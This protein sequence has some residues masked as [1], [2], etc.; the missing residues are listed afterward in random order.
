M[1]AQDGQAI[2]FA[3][4]GILGSGVGGVATIGGRNMATMIH[5]I[6]HS[7]GG[8]SDEYTA[9]QAGRKKGAKPTRNTNIATS[10]DPDQ[11][12]WSHFLKAKVRGVGMHPGGA[13]FVKGAWRPTAGKCSMASGGSFCAVCRE[14]LVLRIY[15]YCDPI[16]AAE[17][18]AHSFDGDLDLPIGRRGVSFEVRVLQ[19][20]S[21][22]L[23]VDWWLLP[24][25]DAP[26]PID[27][28]ERKRKKE[29]PAGSSAK[30]QVTTGP[31]GRRVA[32]PVLIQAKPAKSTHPNR[33]G[34]HKFRV[35]PT[36][37]EPGRYRVV[38]RVHDSTE[39]RG[40]RAPW[41][42]K[43]NEG[44]LTSTVGWWVRLEE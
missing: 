39:V 32:P 37:L 9:L 25:D 22:E 15:S 12:P 11:S 38:C 6:G 20:T 40:S 10:K 36:G 3:K 2:V 19:P 8:L 30:S 29:G 44:F 34:V 26:R 21:H 35:S 27:V 28:S 23:E 31:G 17:P 18:K 13:Q 5:E 1:R 16:E 43:K 4:L 41:V 42:M 7:F 24:E 33:N 14:E